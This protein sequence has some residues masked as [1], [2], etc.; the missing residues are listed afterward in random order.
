VQSLLQKPLTAG[1]AATIALLNN[2]GMTAKLEELAISEAEIVAARRLPNPTVEGAM[3]FDGDGSPELEVGAMID[4]TDL[5][6]LASRSGAASA[7]VEAAKLDAIGSILDLS[8]DAR[9]AFYDY[10]AAAELLAL[11]RTVLQSFEASAD[12]ATR[13]HEAGNITELD[14]AN[15]RSSFEEAR[16]ELQQAEL[17]F[18]SARERLN[19]MLGLWGRG[20]E[21][22]AES[23][24]PPPPERELETSS[25]EHAAI[26]RSLDLAIAKRRFTAAAR[27][28][29]VARARG[30][31]PE[32]KAGVSAERDDEWAVGP[33]VEIEVP[34][35][36]QGQ[37]EIGV[38]AAQMR[39]EQSL[40]TE[41]AV[42][43]RA[44]AR[45]TAVELK[46][47]REAALYY[48][49]VL[50]PLKQKVVDQ[51]QLEYNA[52]LIGLF[53]LL[54]TKRDQVQTA[55]MYVQRLRDYWIA[56]TNAEQLLAGRRHR[57]GSLSAQA[58]ARVG[59]P[60]A[61]TDLH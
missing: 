37:G 32:L 15:Q 3:R 54:Q 39:R 34:L 42:G 57:G 51:S 26:S 59:R 50:L 29:N 4:L 23:R 17:S 2:R 10:Q 58:D 30:L 18:A 20:V 60:S 31:L 46:G 19:A 33:A 52:M 24:L 56:R 36:Y 5:L 53:Q 48:K 47:T 12:L 55:A 21:W 38:A 45:A 6:L 1:S 61:T 13:L 22:N 14:L 35:F 25:L 16:L 27:R 43:I 41:A 44:A 7:A 28:A 9:R 11:R 40:Y 49:N 8:F